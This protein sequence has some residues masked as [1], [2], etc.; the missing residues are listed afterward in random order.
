MSETLKSTIVGTIIIGIFMLL[1]TKMAT[2]SV[3]NLAYHT[4]NY[5]EAE[6]VE[7][8]QVIKSEQRKAKDVYL[9][10][11]MEKLAPVSAKAKK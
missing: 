9:E 7:L 4:R 10:G 8:K 6:K 1:C 2:S 3:W 5:I 11:T